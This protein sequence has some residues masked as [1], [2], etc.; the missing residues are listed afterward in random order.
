MCTVP[1]R[2]TSYATPKFMFLRECTQNPQPYRPS[3]CP[4]NISDVANFSKIHKYPGIVVMS[5]YDTPRGHC[6]IVVVRA[7]TH[8]WQLRTWQREK[9]N[10]ELGRSC[11]I[12]C[13]VTGM[14]PSP[15]QLTTARMECKNTVFESLDRFEQWY[16]PRQRRNQMCSNYNIYAPNAC[17]ILF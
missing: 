11:T 5:P 10:D 6:R 4:I 1:S 13:T 17:L 8:Q 14:S 3:V 7:G 2:T 15:A 16:Q 9:N 12:R